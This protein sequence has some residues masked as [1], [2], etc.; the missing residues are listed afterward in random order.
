MELEAAFNRRRSR[1]MRRRCFVLAAFS[2]GG[3]PLAFCF[4]A[5]QKAR[6]NVPVESL[7]TETNAARCR[8]CPREARLDASG[9]DL[10]QWTAVPVDRCIRARAPGFALS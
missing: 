5:E 2:S 8:L 9:A 1:P 7:R 6:P 4:R 10:A 3:S